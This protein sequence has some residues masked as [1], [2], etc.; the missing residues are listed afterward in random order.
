MKKTLLTPILVAISFV[1]F[2]QTSNL[3]MK[4]YKPS[5]IYYAD[6]SLNIMIQG[7]K[8]KVTELKEMIDWYRNQKKPTP[9]VETLNEYLIFYNDTPY[10]KLS[11]HYDLIQNLININQST[12]RKRR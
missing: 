2:S 4:E 10:I 5:L 7:E 9:K 6:S 1:S 8:Y 12:K 3:L 11:T